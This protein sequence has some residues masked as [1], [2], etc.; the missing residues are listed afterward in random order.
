MRNA[1]RHVFRLSCAVF[2]FAITIFGT[3]ACVRAQT[4]SAGPAA[5]PAFE[6]ATIKPAVPFDPSKFGPRISAT[7]ATYT[8]QSLRDLIEVAYHVKPPQVS[9]PRLIDSEHYDIVATIPEGAAEADADKMLQAL[10]KER[11]KLAF[12]IEKRDEPT[13]ALVVGKNGAK[14]K[15]SPPD[16]PE[17]DPD[18]PLKPGETYI[19]NTKS[20]IVKNPDGSST[21]NMGKRGTLT[22]KFDRESRTIHEERSKMTMEELAEELPVR[23]GAGAYEKYMVIDETGLKGNYQVAMDYPLPGATASDGSASDPEGAGALTRSLDALG[24]K[25]ELR[26]VPIDV[27]VIDHVEKPSEN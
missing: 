27:Y 3:A 4:A 19:G 26:K 21:L 23:M 13:Y 14:L 1:S 8:Y 2:A 17:S 25:L 10:L 9:G 18:A 20:K 7:R 16:S 12:H 22:N 15:P 24:L 11:F 6:V 5:A